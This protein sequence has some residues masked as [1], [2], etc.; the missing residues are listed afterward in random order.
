MKGVAV[1][2]DESCSARLCHLGPNGPVIHSD[3]PRE[4]KHYLI[5]DI[6]CSVRALNDKTCLVS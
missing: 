2:G 5:K 4:W 3:R 1:N 6:A